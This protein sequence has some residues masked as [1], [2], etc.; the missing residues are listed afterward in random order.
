MHYFTSHP[1]KLTSPLSLRLSLTDVFVS[2]TFFA[3]INPTRIIVSLVQSLNL[4][5]GRFTDIAFCSPLDLLL[6]S[7]PF[8]HSPNFEL[9]YS[10]RM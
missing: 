8:E 6:Q 4:F 2:S 9:V 1:R 5:L 3:E 10:V 7:N